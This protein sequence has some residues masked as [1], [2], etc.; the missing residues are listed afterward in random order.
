MNVKEAFAGAF[1][2]VHRVV[3]YDAVLGM[4][5]ENP[6]LV[7]ASHEIVANDA[8]D[9]VE[10]VATEGRVA[11]GDAH[12]AIDE[13][14]ALDQAIVT[15]F[16]D[17]DCSSSLAS[18]PLDLYEDVVADGPAMGVFDV[19]AADVIAVEA[20]WSIRFIVGESFGAIVLKQAELDTAV[21]RI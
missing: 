3:G 14:V 18:S 15:L 19:Y 4:A 10:P 12:V 16:G 9:A 11:K 13:D 5:G 17:I 6:C 2:I 20:F 7:A 8:V 21:T 1:G